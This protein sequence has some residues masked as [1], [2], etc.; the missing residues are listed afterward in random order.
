MISA[1]SGA[2]PTR[3]ADGPPNRQ[4]GLR[5]CRKVASRGK[6]RLV[7]RH[8]WARSSPSTSPTSVACT[9]LPA[10]G[11]PNTSAN[12]HGRASAKR[13][14][15]D[16][17]NVVGGHQHDYVFPC[18]GHEHRHRE[19]GFPAFRHA[20]FLGRPGHSAGDPAWLRRQRQRSAQRLAPPG[21]SSAFFCIP[22][23]PFSGGLWSASDNRQMMPPH[24]LLHA[25]DS[26]R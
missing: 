4:P 16:L 10:G 5:P 13:A 3:I 24:P 17:F 22:A 8:K 20:R 12:R 9:L 21:S 18:A 26:G 23:A 11:F 14:V 7:W 19:S 2:P 15:M 6:R 25:P 1:T